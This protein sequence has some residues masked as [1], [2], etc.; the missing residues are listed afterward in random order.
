MHGWLL[1]NLTYIFKYKRTLSYRSR[2]PNCFPG[3]F[4]VPF[5][6]FRRTIL[7]NLSVIYVMENRVGRER[8]LESDMRNK[9]ICHTRRNVP[10]KLSV[11]KVCYG[12]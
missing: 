5:Q 9:S 4:K 6:L 7:N 3:V 11:Y 2:L 12:Q 1:N 8:S 10:K